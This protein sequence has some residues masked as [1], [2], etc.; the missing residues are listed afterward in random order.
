MARQPAPQEG[1]VQFNKDSFRSLLT[2]SMVGLAACVTLYASA[3]GYHQYAKQ[4]TT[5][6]LSAFAGWVVEIGANRVLGVKT[7]ETL[8]CRAAVLATMTEEDRR[9]VDVSEAVVEA[10]PQEQAQPQENKTPTA[11]ESIPAQVDPAQVDAIRTLNFV[12]AQRNATGMPLSPSS[13]APFSQHAGAPV[14]AIVAD[15]NVERAKI[16][17]QK[18]PPKLKAYLEANPSVGKAVREKADK[19]G[20]QL[21]QAI[22]QARER[23]LMEAYSLVEAITD[24]PVKKLLTI[25]F[26]ESELGAN[27]K[28]GKDVLQVKMPTFL[29]GLVR[30][31][32]TF[33]QLVRPFRPALADEVACLLPYVKEKNGRFLFDDAGYRRDH[34]GKPLHVK[35]MKKPRL[36]DKAKSFR[37]DPFVAGMF[38]ALRLKDAQEKIRSRYQDDPKA[39]EFIDVMGSHGFAR[40]VHV[41]GEAGV[42]V[43]IK[44]RNQPAEKGFPNEG[45][46]NQFKIKDQELT[47]HV[48]CRF[49]GVTHITSEEIDRLVGQEDA[50]KKS[51]VVAFNALRKGLH[52]GAVPPALK[53]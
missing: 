40:L 48:C 19:V 2:N 1:R 7:P 45:I 32:D 38:T 4:V 22:D 25:S 50:P 44:N 30:Y 11:E 29:D 35:G 37:D 31:G 46:R 33:V 15:V 5:P 21:P 34:Q 12:E 47:R 24:F 43:A 17:K 36:E 3:H 9:P 27:P 49:A 26:F 16:E 41:F 14:V 18:M 52:Q 6:T 10:Q 23:G 39:M 51:S 8:A 28:A 20:E 42:N 13:Y 53:L